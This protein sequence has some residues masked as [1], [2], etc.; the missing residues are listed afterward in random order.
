MTPHERAL[1]LLRLAERDEQA[2]HVLRSDSSID[3]ATLGFHYQQAAEKLLKSLLAK[4]NIT[5]PRTHDLARLVELVEAAGYELP[6]DSDALDTLTPFA[7]TFRY[8]FDETGGALDREHTQ[9]LIQE[10]REW[11][12]EQLR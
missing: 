12:E 6:V 3:D 9:S 1:E 8:E 4:Q 5:F 7:V 11:V 10:L 2:A